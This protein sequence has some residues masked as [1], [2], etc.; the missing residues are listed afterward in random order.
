MTD[1][2]ARSIIGAMTKAKALASVELERDALVREAR[3]AGESIARA[4]I[5]LAKVHRYGFLAEARN[6]RRCRGVV[7][8]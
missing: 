1:A 2:Y 4:G 3:R 6:R 7:T 8:F 5:D